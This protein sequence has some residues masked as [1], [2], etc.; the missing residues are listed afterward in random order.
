MRTRTIFLIGATAVLC[1]AAFFVGRM[2]ASHGIITYSVNGWTTSVNRAYPTYGLPLMEDS[3][4]LMVLREGDTTNAIRVLDAFM[5][6]SLYDAMCRRPLLHGHDRETL[7]KVLAMA[8]RY[9]EQHPWQIDTSTNGF[10]NPEQLKQYEHWIEEQKR[11][12]A[13]LRTFV[14]TNEQPNTALK[15]N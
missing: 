11:V 10:G 7:D 13:F 8:A 12:D 14:V 5:E 2:S 15:P 3:T 9:R 6:L 1:L 4:L